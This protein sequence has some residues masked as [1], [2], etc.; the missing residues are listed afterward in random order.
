MVAATM[1][2]TTGVAFSGA[3]ARGCDSEPRSGSHG[4]YY[5]FTLEQLRYQKPDLICF[6]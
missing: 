3:V 5:S 4:R 2:I 6:I 1:V